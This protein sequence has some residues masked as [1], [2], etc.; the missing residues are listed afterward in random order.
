[1]P[2]KCDT[3]FD[4]VAIMRSEM[5][6]FK[7]KYFWR[8]NKEGGSREDPMELGSF[9]YGL[10]GDIQRVDAVYERT[11][12]DMVFFVGNKYYVMS[13]NN[14]LKQGP[15]PITD[16][17]LP[18]DLDHIDGAMRWGWND[19]TYFFSGTMY[20]RYDEEVRHVELDYPRDMGMWSGVPHNI[21]AVFQYHDKKTYFFKGKYFWE[22]NNQKMKVTEDSPKAVGEYW[23]HCP[24]ELQDP[25]NKAG[26]ATS[27]S[28][29]LRVTL[30]LLLFLLSILW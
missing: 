7:G 25:F 12:N 13:G 2:D 29:R 4:A 11:N 21:D 6:V 16:L 15:L 23:L 8:I 30:N 26:S 20:W 5:W 10:P 24:K 1:L 28:L 14:R 19:K 17:G 3:N 27:S 9:W 18:A 22:F